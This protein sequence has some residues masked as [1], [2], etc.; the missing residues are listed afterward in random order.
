[1]YQT[2]GDSG[3]KYDWFVT[4]GTITSGTGTN[5]ITLH[6]PGDQTGTVD[7][8]ETTVYGCTKDASQMYVTVLR[9]QMSPSPN[10]CIGQPFTLFDES[11]VPVKFLWKFGDGDS[12]TVENPTHT[13]KALGKYIVNLIVTSS[14]GCKDSISQSI[15]VK[16]LPDAHWKVGSLLNPNIVFKAD[17]STQK[18]TAYDWDFGDGSGTTSIFSSY[19]PTH[20]FPKNKAY[21]VKLLITDSNGCYN[22]HD[23]TLNVKASGIENP[24]LE[25]LNLNIYPNP[26]QN[27]AV[28]E[29]TL[30]KRTNIQIELFTTSGTQISVLSQG[31]QTPGKHQVEISDK[32]NLT[33]GLYIIK[34]TLD[35]QYVS[36]DIVKH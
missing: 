15:T 6:W 23:S 7:L 9:P 22:E 28:V 36:R 21:L 18:E 32:F 30:T 11:I 5:K 8:T 14:S 12:L 20:I 19:D 1:M 29:Y 27:S 26:F 10:A 34:F 16:I 35:G 25:S 4:G 2:K 33:P 3:S 24:L 13:Y 31:I 17:D